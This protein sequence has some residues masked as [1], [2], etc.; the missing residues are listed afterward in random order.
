MYVG[1][2]PS[3]HASVRPCGP[4]AQRDS[5][6]I[7]LN[8]AKFRIIFRTYSL[9]I[10]RATPFQASYSSPFQQYVHNLHL[11]IP[12]ADSVPSRV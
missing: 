5:R 6:E 4:C 3:C 1:K 11:S 8:F 10:E 9:G 12:M 2:N 7:I